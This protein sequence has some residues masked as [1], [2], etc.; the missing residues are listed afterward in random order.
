MEHWQSQGLAKLLESKVS[1][2]DLAPWWF[3]NVFF[4]C[5][6]A[7][8]CYAQCATILGSFHSVYKIVACKPTRNASRL[9]KS[10]VDDGHFAWARGD[11]P[12]RRSPASPEVIRCNGELVLSRTHQ[13]LTSSASPAS[14]AVFNMTAI[15]GYVDYCFFFYIFNGMIFFYLQ[16]PITDDL[17]YQLANHSAFRRSVPEIISS[18]TIQTR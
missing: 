1:G 4:L 8:M 15:Q 14:P 11:R 5:V 6:Y 10:E 13:V 12:G 3:F 18:P 16:S 2:N 17:F 9:L 7:F